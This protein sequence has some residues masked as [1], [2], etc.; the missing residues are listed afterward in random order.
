MGFYFIFQRQNV[1]FV[2]KLNILMHLFIVGQPKKK[3][4]FGLAKLKK[5]K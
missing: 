3:I 5:K 1:A 2:C 4:L